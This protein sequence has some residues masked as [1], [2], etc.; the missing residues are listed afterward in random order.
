[1]SEATRSAQAGGCRKSGRLAGKAT[2]TYNTDTT[3]SHMRAP[4]HF[5]V[6]SNPSKDNIDSPQ[7]GFNTPTKKRRVDRIPVTP[8]SAADDGDFF[9]GEPE[10]D[11]DIAEPEQ[12]SGDDD[13]LY[14]GGRPRGRA[15]ARKALKSIRQITTETQRNIDALT[16]QPQNF[17]NPGAHISDTWELPEYIL[18]LEPIHPMLTQEE[19][20]RIPEAPGHAIY[21]R[22][23]PEPWV[24]PRRIRVDEYSIYLY[25][26]EGCKTGE[27]LWES[28]LSS[29][30]FNGPRTSAPFRELYRL[31][32]PDPSDMSDWAENIR[33]AKL[34]HSLYGSDTW[35]EYD[36]H[37]ER[38]TQERQQEFWFSSEFLDHLDILWDG[39][40]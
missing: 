24:P 11:D 38:I 17:M 33:W 13:V 21:P 3:V 39:L 1:V 19:I 30:R 22:Y 31:T 9:Q 27:E 10:A 23:I 6:T 15:A 18:P 16:A 14:P 26:A 32:D 5:K 7:S 36:H 8:G 35:S 20:D 37:L 25:A 40:E 4:N 29:T 28:A 2:I 12:A 34:Q